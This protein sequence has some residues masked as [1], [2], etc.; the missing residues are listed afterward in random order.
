MISIIVVVRETGRIKPDYSLKFS[1][2]QVPA[3]GSYISIQRPN[4]AAPFGEDLIVRQGWWRLAHP[5]PRFSV[6]NEDREKIGTLNEI[7]VECD[8]VVGPYSSDAWR[9]SQEHGVENGTVE[10]M[11]TE[12]FSIRESDMDRAPIDER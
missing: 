12:R 6:T 8:P 2:P 1:V 10:R 7:F 3:V 5:E 4:K 9:F 11:Q